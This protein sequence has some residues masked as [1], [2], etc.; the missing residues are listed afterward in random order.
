MLKVDNARLDAVIEVGRLTDLPFRRL[1]PNP[2]ALLDS[3]LRGILGV[4]LHSR[5]GPLLTAPRQLAMLGVEVHRNA[6]ARRGDEGVLGTPL[7]IRLRRHRRL[8]VLG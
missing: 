8:D 4:Y 1:D 2:V 6:A 5:S 3:K 7:G